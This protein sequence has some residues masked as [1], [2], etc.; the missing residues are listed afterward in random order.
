MRQKSTFCTQKNQNVNITSLPL[1]HLLLQSWVLTFGNWPFSTFLSCSDCA[2]MKCPPTPY[3]YPAT[4]PLH[5]IQIQ[6]QMQ[7]QIKVQDVTTIV[8]LPSEQIFSWSALNFQFV[9]TSWVP[10]ALVHSRCWE[11]KEMQRHQ[12]VAF[13][14]CTRLWNFGIVPGCGI[15]VFSLLIFSLVPPLAIKSSI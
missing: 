7:I 13:W 2:N 15:K 5:K 9:L 10:G 11:E 12:I 8:L 4:A 14:H 3:H 1:S 6:I